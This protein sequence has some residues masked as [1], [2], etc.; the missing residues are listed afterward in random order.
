MTHTAIHSSQGG[1]W[2]SRDLRPW[3]DGERRYWELVSGRAHE[4]VII[5]REFAQAQLPYVQKMNIADFHNF[6]VK[7]IKWKFTR[8]RAFKVENFEKYYENP[9]NMRSL[10][11]IREEI[12]NLDYDNLPL[13][14]MVP[15]QIYG[16]KTAAAPGLLS[17]LRPEKFGTVDQFLIEALREVP[18]IANQWWFPGVYERREALL[19][20][21]GVRLVQVLRA[22]ASA[23]NDT[24]QTTEWTPRR[25]DMVLWARGRDIVGGKRQTLLPAA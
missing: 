3:I 1:T 4:I 6:I 2:H 19:P 17:I 15:S 14:I 21:D 20:M 11:E 5:E 10:N 12:L 25:V 22:K 8:F 13:A 24:F 16:I 18:T 9:N 7:F 23:L